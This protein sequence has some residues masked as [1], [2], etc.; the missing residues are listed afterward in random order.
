MRS[1]NSVKN[2][3]FAIVGQAVSLI[4]GFVTRKVFI[5]VL[6][7][8]YLGINGV[9]CSILSLLSLTELGIG[10][11]ITFSLY[12]PI[13]EHDD[14]QTGRIMNLYALAYRL[15]ALAVTVLVLLMLRNKLEGGAENEH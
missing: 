1:E 6:G 7:E 4:F 12:K 9:F 2:S 13:A 11:A 3:L 10:S 5:N 15:V 14:E 8:T